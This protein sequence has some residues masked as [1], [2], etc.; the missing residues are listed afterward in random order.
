MKY[1]LQLKKELGKLKIWESLIVKI[2]F[3]VDKISE[4]DGKGNKVVLGWIQETI[5][6]KNSLIGMC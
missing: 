6:Q 3:E 5:L 4:A 1:G 2:I